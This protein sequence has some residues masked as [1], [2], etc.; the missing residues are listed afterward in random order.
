MNDDFID[1][2]ILVYTF[3]ETDVRKRD[4]ADALIRRALDN[5]GVI[6]FQVVQEVLNV[7]VRKYRTPGSSVDAKV[8]LAHVLEPLWKVMPTPALYQRALDLQQRYRYRF[9]DSLII[10]AALTAGCTR[11]YSEDLQHGQQ[12][13]GLTIVD[14]FRE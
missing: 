13:E 4:A 9:Y 1:S 6:S 5:G 12:I 10:A 7:V 14:P 3:S 11:L 8:F 2:N